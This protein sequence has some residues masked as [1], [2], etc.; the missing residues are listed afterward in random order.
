MLHDHLPEGLRHANG[1]EVE[2]D[3]G[4][5]APGENKTI[6]LETTAVKAGRFVNQA[7]ASGDDG[8]QALAQVAVVVTQPAQQQRRARWLHESFPPNQGRR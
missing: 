2:T 1:P 5:L 7:V 6:M 8:L 3:M 4:T